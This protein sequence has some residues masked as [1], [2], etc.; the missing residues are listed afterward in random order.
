MP[1]L[2]LKMDHGKMVDSLVD[3]FKEYLGDSYHCHKTVP[4]P[5]GA[6][7]AKADCPYEHELFPL[8]SKY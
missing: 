4:F 2:Q 6:S 8:R 1:H 3:N 7:V 5:P